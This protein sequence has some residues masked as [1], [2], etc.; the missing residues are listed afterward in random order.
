M[1][2]RARAASGPGPR[3]PRTRSCPA[4]RLTRSCGSQ[5]ASQLPSR[6][7]LANA[8]TFIRVRRLAQQRHSSALAQ[9][10]SR[11]SACLRLGTALGEDPVGKVK[12]LSGTLI[13]KTEQEAPGTDKR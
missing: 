2:S 4:S 10:A 6:A 9:H 11:I 12:A 5:A 13:D 3:P 1:A 7:D 8:E